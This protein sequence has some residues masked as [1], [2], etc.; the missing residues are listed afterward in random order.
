MALEKSKLLFDFGAV[1]FLSLLFGYIF[2]FVG[3]PPVVGYLLSGLV[4][5]PQGLNIVTDSEVITLM[6]SLG[7]ILLLFFTGLK[8]N[9]KK[10][11]EAGMYAIL[12]SPIKSG[13]VFITGY[14]IAKLL[15][16]TQLEAFI[17]GA[18][19]AGSSTAI[20]SHAILAHGW[21]NRKEA[22]IAMSMLILEDLLSVF[23]I[24]YLLGMVNVEVPVVK[25][26]I[27]TFALAFLLFVITALISRKL[28]TLLKEVKQ[29]D[30]P[31]YVLGIIT[32]FSYGVSVLGISPVLG[33]FFA[34]LALSS[35]RFAE[36]L[37]NKMASYRNF[38]VLFFFTS[39][40]LKYVFSFSETAILLALLSSIAVWVQ[41]FVVLLVGP[42][43]GLSPDRAA[44]LGILMLPLGEFSLFFS[45]VAQELGL[46]HAA[47]M[48]GGMFLAIIITTL[49]GGIMIKYEKEYSEIAKRFVPPFLRDVLSPYREAAMKFFLSASKIPSFERNLL[50]FFISS[51]ILFYFTGYLLTEAD[52]GIVPFVALYTA[53]S[54]LYGRFL[55]ELLRAVD[56]IN[57]GIEEK[58]GPEINRHY[59]RIVVGMLS[60]LLGAVMLVAGVS[61]G[62][63]SLVLMS[64]AAAIFGFVIILANLFLFVVKR[65]A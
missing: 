61:L 24:A 25:V 12:L 30:I 53:A 1:L 42:M 35:T 4:L 40:G 18:A 59:T 50:I 46:P 2:E 20:I 33:A 43:V 65:E 56:Y 44:R 58:G 23:F 26:F 41:V 11:G 19:L 29:E 22:R 7:I 47:D 17:V 63:L 28:S 21:N 55:V 39:L 5:G 14:Y 49:V 32:L 57:R 3:L 38:F 13:A 27:H 9:P 64:Y 54:L 37:Y 16:F 34:G 45:A 48:M 31:L 8:M 36:N 10:F 62:V 51:Y 15:G 52:I 60:I 6:S